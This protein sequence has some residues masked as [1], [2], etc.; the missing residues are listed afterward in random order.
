M[1]H[2]VLVG[3]DGQGGGLDAAA[4]ARQLVAPD[5]ELVLVH[6]DSGYPIPARGATGD[7][8]H[9]RLVV[10]FRRWLSASRRT[11]WS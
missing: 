10:A 1:F 4:L 2:K 5:G 6:I 9:V 8:E 7:F 3:I 11:W